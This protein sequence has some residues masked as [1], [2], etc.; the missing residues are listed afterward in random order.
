MAE[1][2]SGISPKTSHKQLIW[3]V[4]LSAT[5]A[6]G[7]IFARQ[8]VAQTISDELEGI[9]KIDTMQRLTGAMVG[10][11]VKVLPS[12][13]IATS[14]PNDWLLNS[15]EQPVE[16]YQHQLTLNVP[17]D[18]LWAILLT[19]V[20]LNA[21]VYL[22]GQLLGVEG[23]MKEPITHNWNRPLMFS[24]PNGLL[25]AGEN[26]LRIEVVTF[27]PGHGLLGDVYLAPH[28]QLSVIANKLYFVDVEFPRFVT[29]VSLMMTLIVFGIWLLRRKDTQY[30][31]F[32]LALLLWSMYSLRNHVVDAPISS[33]HWAWFQYI[34]SIG[35]SFP[36]YHFLMR[37]R[38]LSRTRFDGLIN[39]FWFFSWSLVTYL[40]LADNML[41]YSIAEILFGLSFITTTGALINV[42]L[43]SSRTNNSEAQWIAMTFSFLVVFVFHDALQ[44]FG[45]FDRSN[46]LLVVYAMPLLL[47][48]F[49]V[50]MLR[51][52][53]HALSEREEVLANLQH[54]AEQAAVRIVDLEKRTALADQRETIMRDMHD[55]VGGQLVSSLAILDKGQSDPKL[56]R[57]VLQGALT[58]LR[59]MIDSLDTDSDDLNLL[60]GALRERMEPILRSAGFE[61]NWQ[62]AELPRSK[63]ITP[64]RALQILRIL[65]EALTNSIKHG[66]TNKINFTAAYDKDAEVSR[67]SVKDGGVGFDTSADYAGRGLLN[68]QRRAADVGA[69]IHFYSEPNVGSEVVIEIPVSF[70]SE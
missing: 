70:R 50:I 54:R 37:F 67:L 63:N 53:A 61:S 13:S 59:L 4:L 39:G 52:F 33:M 32:A 43:Y 3:V 10:P 60:L 31:W 35:G 68:M 36:M 46:G 8:W 24:I 69:K 45:F 47:G 64:H 58:D 23:R 30:G 42:A 14:L 66:S 27:P 5:L 29:G 34:C 41:M 40:L 17:P 6:M 26:D 49:G 44:I 65:Q 18:R 28:E 12:N 1:L 38:G 56:L 25:R 11:D 21:A 9:V 7:V 16:W 15:F 2:Q 48:V 57:D 55:G 19:R 20:N 51:R 22:N 62:I